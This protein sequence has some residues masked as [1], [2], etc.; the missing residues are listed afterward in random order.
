MIHWIHWALWFATVTCLISGVPST[1]FALDQT[2]SSS[3]P[4]AGGVP[5]SEDDAAALPVSLDRIRNGLSTPLIQP[6]FGRLSDRPTF[7]LAIQ[8]RQK[9]E[10]LVAKALKIEPVLVPPG[11]LYG[12][13]QQRLVFNPTDHPLMQPYAAFSG[14]QLVTIAVENLIAR[15]LGGRMLNAMTTAQRARAEADARAEVAH[16]IGDY[17]AGQTD[18]GSGLLMCREPP[19]LP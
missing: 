1:A 13:E 2:Q 19:L 9:F 15:Y 14:G 12:F 16:A 10:E 17:C 6:M 5:A 8:E 3:T 11:G 4:D 18:G 7:T